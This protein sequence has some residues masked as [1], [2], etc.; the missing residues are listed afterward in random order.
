MA[1]EFTKNMLIVLVA[2]MMGFVIITYFIA[3]I[4]RRSDLAELTTKKNIEINTIEGRNVN[5]TDHFLESSILLDTAREDRSFGDYHFDLARLFYTGALAENGESEMEYYK[6][7][8]I[9]NCT[10][11]MQKYLY[12]NL[13]FKSSSKFFNDTK[14]Y[15]T[16][17]SYTRLLNLYFNLTMSG[18]RLTM[19]RYN[20]SMYLKA[21][22]ENL[23]MVNGSVGYLT[24][25]SDLLNLYNETN[26][27]Y[28]AELI[29]YNDYNKM[30]QEYD[31]AGFS[32]VRES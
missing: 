15:T 26:G 23:T 25:V 3:D 6:T 32:T 20:A 5:F 18:A 31:I 4:V 16:V 1:R 14:Q 27:M 2:I 30:I 21:L 13:N 7:R 29:I 8:T 12:S 22:A 24:N 19:L 28:G 17:S 10:N 9:D 11:A